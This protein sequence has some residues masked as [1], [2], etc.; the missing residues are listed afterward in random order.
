MAV[1]IVFRPP[2]IPPSLNGKDGLMRLHWSKRKPIKEKFMWL[3]KDRKVPKMEGKYNLTI[4]NYYIN[5]MDWD[6]LASRFKI[7]GDA[8]VKLKLLKDDSPEFIVGF[9]LEQERVKKR[10]YVRI[11]FKFEKE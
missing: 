9:K 3:I 7:I 5:W 11:E 2:D 4:T 1:I 10:A 6:N 8:L